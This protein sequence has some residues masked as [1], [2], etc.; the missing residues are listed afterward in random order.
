M[1]RK[2]II[3]ILFMFSIIEFIHATTMCEQS[4]KF[5]ALVTEESPCFYIFEE[6]SGE[7]YQLRLHKIIL[8]N[9]GIIAKFDTYEFIGLEEEGTDSTQ[10]EIIE[11]IL[12]YSNEI[13]EKLLLYGN[14]W[15]KE[16][17]NWS[18]TEPKTNDELLEKAR[19]MTPFIGSLWNEQYGLKGIMFPEFQNIETK[20]EYFHPRGLYINYKITGVYYFPKKS[21]LL[22][23]T[24][25]E[26]KGEGLDTMHGF[27]IFKIN[28]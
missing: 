16:H 11:P 28:N 25:Q 3:S 19:N 1:K 18:I 5:I 2:L 24:E 20:L 4:F 12:R 14:V 22:L 7:C 27:L 17:I 10:K 9:E 15:K 23:F 6:L 21:F 13:P 26:M 8:G